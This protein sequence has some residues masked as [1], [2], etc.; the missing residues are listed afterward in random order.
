MRTFWAEEAE[1]FTL[2]IGQ[3][4]ST[5][6]IDDLGGCEDVHMISALIMWCCA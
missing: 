5:L 6:M 1:K 3:T 4:V 2:T